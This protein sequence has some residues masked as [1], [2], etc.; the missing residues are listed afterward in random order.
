MPNNDNRR[1]N[2][3]L[4]HPKRKKKKNMILNV[5]IAVVLLLIIIVVVNIVVDKEPETSKVDDSTSVSEE[6]NADTSTND[7]EEV[8]E[9]S[10]ETEKDTSEENTDSTIQTPSQEENNESESSETEEQENVVSEPSEDPVVEEV[11]VDPSWAPIGTSQSG[12]HASSYDSNSVDYKEK[13][14]ALSY[15]SGLDS[16][17]M[18]VKRLGNGG[19]PQKSIGTVTSKDG[20]E[21]YRIYLEWVDGEGWKPTKKEKLTTLEDAP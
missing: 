9:D 20:K 8:E 10:T 21:I 18:F 12:E 4:N 2:S 17:N 5:L 6:A 16:S 15:G 1:I 19:S 11:V 14:Q 3:R 13:V 7:D